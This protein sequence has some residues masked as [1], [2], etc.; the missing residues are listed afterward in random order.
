MAVVAKH[1]GSVGI[2]ALST[3][4]SV[5]ERFHS[6]RIGES[7]SIYSPAT[8]ERLAQA[9]GYFAGQGGDG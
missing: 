4:V 5:S 9:T 7:V 1:R 2:A 3:L 8:Q 6:L